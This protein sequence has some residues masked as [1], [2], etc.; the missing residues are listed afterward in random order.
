MSFAGPRRRLVD[1]VFARLGED[2]YWGLLPD[3]VRVR[4]REEDAAPMY[5][6]LAEIARLRFVMVRRSDVAVPA[7]DDVVE[8]LDE[9]GAPSGE[10]FRLIAEPQI[11]RNGV[12]R[13]EVTVET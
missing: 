12:W 9:S 1:A 10:K 11:T 7:V 6:R 8:L 5:D 4:W 2:A 13:C 3:P